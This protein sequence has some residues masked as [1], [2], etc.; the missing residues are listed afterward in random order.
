MMTRREMHASKRKPTS[1]KMLEFHQMLVRIREMVPPNKTWKRLQGRRGSTAAYRESDGTVR[2]QYHETDVVVCKPDNTVT[3]TSGGWRTPTTKER[4][5]W[6]LWP[7]ASLYQQ[8]GVWYIAMQGVTVPFEDG[9]VLNGRKPKVKKNAEA[10]QLKL[11]KLVHE[12]AESYVDQLRKGNIP[13]PSGGDCWMCGLQTT[14]GQGLGEATKDTGHLLS[15]IS[16]KERYY[17]PSLMVRAL[18]RR[19]SR[20]MEALVWS[21][22]S[23]QDVGERLANDETLWMEIRKCLRNYLLLQLGLPPT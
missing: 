16:K 22:W 3:L 9:M 11:K 15:Q 2:L 23:G 6:C 10:K 19:S 17:V 1:K 8:G 20:M 13:A 5:S 12:Y 7:Y 14:E 4:I 21:K 18:K